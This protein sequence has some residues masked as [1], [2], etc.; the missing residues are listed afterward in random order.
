MNFFS[1]QDETL[2]AESV[3]LV[4]I[5]ERFGTPS[6][7]YSRAALEFA[8]REFDQACSGRDILICYSVKANSNLAVLNLLAR[9]GSGFDIVSG[10]ELA[11]VLAAGGSAAKAVFSGVGKSALGCALAPEIGRAPGALWLRSGV[12]ASLRKLRLDLDDGTWRRR[13]GHLPWP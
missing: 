6:Y 9:L 13:N 5:A 4:E 1:Y 3:R 8:Y 11:R 2:C 12:E 10:G 7:V